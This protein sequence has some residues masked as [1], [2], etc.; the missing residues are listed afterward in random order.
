MISPTGCAMLVLLGPTGVGKTDIAFQVARKLRGEIISADSRL[1]Y[2]MMDIGTAK[3]DPAMRREI[4]HHMI[5]LVTPDKQFTAKDFERQARHAVREVVDRGRVPVVVGGTGLYVRALLRGIFN[6]P[7]ADRALR[8]RLEEEARRNGPEALW[9]KLFEVDPKKASQIDRANVVRVI[10]ALEVFQLAGRRMSDLEGEARAIET[11]AVK[12]GLARSPVDLKARIEGRVDRMIEAGFIEE[13]R[14]LIDAGYGSSRVVR[15][16]LGYKE[17]LLH[18]E[19]TIAFDEAVAL[20]K[21]NTRRFAK[22]QLTWFARE[23]QVDWINLTG[24]E[25]KGAVSSICREFEERTGA[26]LPQ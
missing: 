2:R 1:V 18:L 12:I 20:I 4:R 23:P 5:D 8:A 19:G 16:T 11:P 21:R 13:V 22:R 26:D 3:P 10:R 15:N 24:L 7:A 9:R 25:D 14:G 6:G 17:L